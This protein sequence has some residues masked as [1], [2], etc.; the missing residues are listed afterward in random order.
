MPVPEVQREKGLRGE[1]GTCRGRFERC[2]GNS[3]LILEVKWG[4][5]IGSKGIMTCSGACGWA[6]GPQEASE[7]VYTPGLMHSMCGEHEDMSIAS[8][9]FSKGL[10]VLRSS[11]RARLAAFSLPPSPQSSSI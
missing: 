2:D 4:Q 6:Q 11:S 3:E 7:T 5:T 9:R 8:S 1:V 10:A